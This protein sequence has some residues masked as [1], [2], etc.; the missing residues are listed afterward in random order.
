[1]ELVDKKLPS[2]EVVRS[3]VRQKIGKFKKADV[4]ELCPSL[5][6][7]SVERGLKALCHSGELSKHG[8]GKSTY[9]LRETI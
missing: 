5:S 7:T 9:Y 2:I 3:A 1:V 8:S 6:A 4:L